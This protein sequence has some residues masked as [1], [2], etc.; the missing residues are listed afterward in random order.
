M[1]R[2]REGVHQASPQSSKTT[3]QQRVPR[4][5]PPVEKGGI[6]VEPTLRLP[7]S[8]LRPQ[9]MEHGMQVTAS[10]SWSPVAL[11]VIL[12]CPC[13]LR[14]FP[15][16]LVGLAAGPSTPAPRTKDQ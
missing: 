7:G 8:G 13:S 11:P 1:E 2:R 5:S 14:S 15:F 16:G 12:F 6:S 4:L 9:G 10:A 3:V